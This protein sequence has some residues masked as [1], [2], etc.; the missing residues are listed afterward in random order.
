MLCSF[1]SCEECRNCRV[2]HPAYCKDSTK[3]NILVVQD[4]YTLR[5]DFGSERRVKGMFFGQS[6]FANLAIV[7][8]KGA[9]LATPLLKDP[10]S[11]DELKLF[12]PL[13]CGL[14]TGSGAVVNVGRV[15]EGDEVVVMG[16]GGVGLGGM[17]AAKVKGAKTIIAVDKVESRLEL[18]KSLG[19][20]HTINTSDIQD[21]AMELPAR[22]KELTEGKEGATCVLDTTGVMPIIAAAL[23]SLATR[24]HLLLVGVPTFVGGPKLEIDQ[25]VNLS[26]GAS[27]SSVRLGDADPAKFIPEMVEW[28]RK[29]LFPI[30]KFSKFYDAEEMQKAFDDM[31]NGTTVKPIL[32]WKESEEDPKAARWQGE[33]L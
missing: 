1:I 11:N 20:T 33:K 17:M 28:Y 30:E 25:T 6:S 29:G 2:G 7:K 31:L 14:M 27:V 15:G 13:G 5:D 4:V 21:L 8:A 23:Q 19:A 22:I 12:A 26:K 24:G 16:V 3:V 10:R 32:V 18:A 9:L